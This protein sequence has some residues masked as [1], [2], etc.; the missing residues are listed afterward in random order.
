MAR[1]LCLTLSLNENDV[2]L[3]DAQ[4]ADV[5][6]AVSGKWDTESWA[7][8]RLAESRTGAALLFMRRGILGS[9]APS[10]P[11][12][13]PAA[14]KRTRGRAGGKLG[15]KLRKTTAARVRKATKARRGSK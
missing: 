12:R 6:E 5:L 15:G 13:K 9:V 14:G 3:L 4:R 10:T 7:T 11:A 1:A 2:K 8:R